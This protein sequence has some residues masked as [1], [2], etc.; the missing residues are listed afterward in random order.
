MKLISCQIENFGTLHARTLSFSAG[1]NLRCENNGFGK[2][3]LAAFLKAMF[4]G[5]P[6]KKTGGENDRAKYRPWQGG[7]FGGSIVF[8]AGGKTYRAERF[9]AD[10]AKGDTF[11]LYDASTNL[12]SDDY[13]ENLGEALFGIDSAAYE[14]T[15]Y[16]PQRMLSGSA[17]DNMSV[18]AKLNGL[19]DAEDDI[20]AYDHAVAKLDKQR[21]A[22]F[23]QGGH[24]R[25][26]ELEEELTRL[27]RECSAC[28]DTKKRAAELRA[29]A[30]SLDA[31]I[32]ETGQKM[33]SLRMDEKRQAYLSGGMELLS[34]RERSAAMILEKRAML[35]PMYGDSVAAAAILDRASALLDHSR[36][37]ETSLAQM[38][39]EKEAADA[40]LAACAGPFPDG[41][42]DQATLEALKELQSAA[43][44]AEDAVSADAS[45]MPEEA[46]Q[47]A[48][49]SAFFGDTPPTEADAKAVTDA[50]EKL[51][52]AEDRLQVLKKEAEDAPAPE[53]LPDDETLAAMSSALTARISADNALS[54]LQQDND[55]EAEDSTE[56]LPT[57]DELNACRARAEALAGQKKRCEAAGAAN[58]RLQKE[59]QQKKRQAQ[60]L[61]AAGVFLLVLGA[62]ATVSFVI[63][64]LGYLLPCGI[65]PL[66]LGIAALITGLIKNRA[67]T[68]TSLMESTIAYDRLCAEYQDN[69]DTVFRF[70]DRYV[71][72]LAPDADEGKFPALFDALSEK[73]RYEDIR[74][75]KKAET[76]QSRAVLEAQSQK[77]GEVLSGL[78]PLLDAFGFSDL[79]SG[80]GLTALTAYTRRIRA[81]Q[82]ERSISIDHFQKNYAEAE[83]ELSTLLRAVPQ[84]EGDTLCARGNA[85]LDMI[86]TYLSLVSSE[87]AR[88]DA[89]NERK[90][91]AALLRTRLE[92]ELSAYRLPA[93]TADAAWEAARQYRAAEQQANSLAAR[94][95]AAMS[96]LA[97]EQREAAGLLSAYPCAAD[98]APAEALTVIRDT[99]KSIDEETRHLRD[100]EKSLR[101][102][103]KEHDLTE[104]DLRTSAADDD[105]SS[106][107]AALEK[108]RGELTERRT[109]LIRQAD[110][111]SAEAEKLPALS[112]RITLTMESLSSA[113]KQLEILQKTKQYLEAARIPS[114]PVIS[115]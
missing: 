70:F 77:A 68:E 46:A 53:D 21:Q 54:A 80:D 13:P 31:P 97:S 115:M 73:I 30:A 8:E 12:P 78:D 96:A 104:D 63:L 42:P 19:I 56:L 82:K 85:L 37:T 79:G 106:S 55:D 107:Y 22:L 50:M 52:Y 108:I 98:L 15:A 23:R 84:T 99:M 83:T 112:E 16:L 17:A 103:L 25:I 105:L 4:Y 88:A 61:I 58:E 72:L 3:T 51:R 59:E 111:Y 35:G 66:V 38:A 95:K 86:R 44:R 76:E 92:E 102:Y 90:K 40:H 64:P 65:V 89:Q 71:P 75:K 74:R 1:L 41:C 101:G 36:Y 57:M 7:A 87:R 27:N 5:M 47:F 114:R 113:R 18:L 39:A 20:S 60:L 11:R 110:I 62:A 67:D 32:K 14:R 43:L 69:R 28:E 9:F 2:S 49:V 33:D 91:R 81:E 26:P 48:R 10:R 6:A 93:C 24:G 45:A 100:T 34:Q 94:Y 109:I 29:E